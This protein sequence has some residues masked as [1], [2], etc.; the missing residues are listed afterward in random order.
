MRVGVG[1]GDAAH[2]VG[3]D[4]GHGERADFVRELCREEGVRE[5]AGGCGC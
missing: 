3:A 2:G 1:E 5:G 4:G